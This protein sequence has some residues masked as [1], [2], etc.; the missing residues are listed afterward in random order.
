MHSLKLDLATIQRV[1]ENENTD[2]SAPC[3][4][5]KIELSE[6]LRVAEFKRIAAQG[7]LEV[8]FEEE[9]NRGSF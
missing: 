6:I 9:I 4:M 5:L 2:L 8:E 7:L 1:I 3:E